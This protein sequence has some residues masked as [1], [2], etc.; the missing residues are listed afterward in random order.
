MLCG[1]DSARTYAKVTQP[2]LPLADGGFQKPRCVVQ[3]DGARLVTVG[4]IDCDI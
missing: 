1:P 3:L 4:M 2:C